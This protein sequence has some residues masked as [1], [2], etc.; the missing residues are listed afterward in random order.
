MHLSYSVLTNHSPYLSVISGTLTLMM[1][2]MVHLCFV[3]GMVITL[4]ATMCHLV[5]GYR[6]E[7]MSQ[8]GYAMNFWT[9]FILFNFDR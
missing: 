4:T 7:P 3:I 8:M 2:D 6:V 9:S 5:Y 1:P